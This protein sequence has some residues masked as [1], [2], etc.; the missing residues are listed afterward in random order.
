MTLG[1]PYE[2]FMVDLFTWSERQCMEPEIGGASLQNFIFSF[3]NSQ[4]R[5]VG[6]GIKIETNHKLP[7]V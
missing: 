6:S 7:G 2:V 5:P 3:I 1:A 4:C